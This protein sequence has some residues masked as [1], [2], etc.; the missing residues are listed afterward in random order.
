MAGVYQRLKRSMK[1]SM[2][3]A[4]GLGLLDEMQDAV[5]GV[6]AGFGHHLEAQH[7][8]RR[9]TAGGDLVTPAAL[10][11]DG[12]AGQGALVKGAEGSSRRASA[13]RRAPGRFR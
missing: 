5:D 2:G 11:R 8:V 4:L 3:R 9:Q 13:A 1:R 6:V 12:F 10:H 7:P